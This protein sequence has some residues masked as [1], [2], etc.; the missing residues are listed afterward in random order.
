MNPIQVYIADDHNLVLKGI[1][2]IMQQMPEIE[3]L[4]IFHNGKQLY[5]ACIQQMPHLVFLDLKMPVWDGRKTLVEL[6]AKY[7]ALRCIVLS[8]N[9][10]KEIID[11]CI[12]KGASGYLYKDCTE[13]EVR[14]AIN[15]ADEIYFSREVLKQ[16]AGYTNSNNKNHFKPTEPLTEREYE[17]LKLLCEGM[18][19]KEI[20]DKIYLSHRTVEVHKHNIMDKF[21]VSSVG[22]LISI[23]LKNNLIAH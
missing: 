10:E 3:S 2:N 12:A 17:I 7:P 16:L 22:K 23:A 18:T 14:E 9:N 1:A 20:A 11:D 5:E 4:Q 19:P 13:D 21:Q 6:K 15:S 8:M